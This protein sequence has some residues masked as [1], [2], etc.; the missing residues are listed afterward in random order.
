MLHHVSFT[1]KNP[2]RVAQALA[3]LINGKVSRFGPWEGGYIAWAADEAGT[4]IE[5]YPH[6]TEI[7]P[8]PDTS[9][10]QFRKNLFASQNT[11]VHTAISVTRSEEEVYRIARQEG[12]RAMRHNRGGFDVI[13]MWI[14]NTVMVEVLTP[15]MLRQYLSII[16]SPHVPATGADLSTIK[17]KAQVAAEPSVLFRSWT[18]TAELQAWWPVPQTNID[19]RVGGPF[20]L[21]FVTDAPLGSRGSEGCKFLSYL[22]GKMV[23]FT[24]NA[25][26]HLA[27]RGMQTWVVL[28]FEAVGDELTEVTLTQAGFLQGEA[29]DQCRTYFQQAWRRVMRRMV[30]HWNNSDLDLRGPRPA[31]IPSTRTNGSNSAVSSNNAALEALASLANTPN[32]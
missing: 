13:E 22:P 4:A 18:S 17:L 26:P 11:P 25:P 20:E 29:W 23:S 16:K 7:I 21:T 6:G 12:W 2:Q 1:A 3:L 10:A 31:R 15:A 28:E 30:D 9:Q 24:W 14:E 32:N 19:L 8:G 27:V 5:V